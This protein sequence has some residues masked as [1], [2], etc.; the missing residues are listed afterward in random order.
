MRN[1]C[2]PRG[3]RTFAWTTGPLVP[4]VMSRHS[5]VAGSPQAG[6]DTAGSEAGGNPA[7]AAV[8]PKSVRAEWVGACGRAAATKVVMA[9]HFL[10][11]ESF[12]PARTGCLEG[13]ETSVGRMVDQANE[14]GVPQSEDA[15]HHPA[16][17]TL[18]EA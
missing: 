7:G 14:D 16:H 3:H 18:D 6:Q 1:Q 10:S 13:V 8:S 11:L 5:T 12:L 2:R 17:M 9:C 4:A 15:H